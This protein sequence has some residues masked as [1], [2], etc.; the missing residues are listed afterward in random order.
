MSDHLYTG[1]LCSNLSLL[2][3]PFFTF[4]LNS[5]TSTALQGCR[6]VLKSMIIKTALIP[7]R[8][9]ANYEKQASLLSIAT[10]AACLDL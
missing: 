5:S 10:A 8:D 7:K 6:D 2:S 4:P 3:F 9:W 1:A